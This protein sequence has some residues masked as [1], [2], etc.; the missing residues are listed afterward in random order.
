VEQWFTGVDPAYRGRG[1]G[2]GLKA[3]MLRYC[4]DRYGDLRWVRTGNSTTNA[5][6]LA[7]NERLGF[8]EYRRYT[9]Y[10]IA[11]D[12]LAAYL[13]DPDERRPGP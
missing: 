12:A 11:R 4:R 8:R 3:A 9:T 7:I 1:L 13:A 5:S 10:Q 6:M 2:K